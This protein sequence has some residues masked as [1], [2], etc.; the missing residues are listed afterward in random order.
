[1]LVF[2]CVGA[3]VFCRVLPWS[4]SWAGLRHKKYTRTQGP[5]QK[6]SY[7]QEK[8]SK[9]KDTQ[10]SAK[11]YEGSRAEKTLDGQGEHPCFVWGDSL[12]E[13]GRVVFFCG[14]LRLYLF[15]LSS[16]LEGVFL[17]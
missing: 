11:S 4:W 16:G 2:S 5:K 6:P 1:M 9:H 3:G 14:A 7:T 13:S 17:R 8:Q 10:M 15:S 12:W